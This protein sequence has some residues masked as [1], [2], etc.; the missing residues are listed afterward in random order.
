MRIFEYRAPIATNNGCCDDKCTYFTNDDSA[1][2]L[3]PLD[4]FTEVGT[5]IENT[6]CF[7]YKGHEK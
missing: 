5:C 4:I 7:Y 3:R 1:C 6:Q 2:L